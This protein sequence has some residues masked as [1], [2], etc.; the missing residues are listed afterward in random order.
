MD[1]ALNDAQVS[2]KHSQIECDGAAFLLRDLGSTN[3]THVGERRVRLCEIEPR[4]EFRMGG[5]KLM[6]V[7][8]ED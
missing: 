1:V 4:T 2:R 7:I 3:G 6:V 5:T 8:A